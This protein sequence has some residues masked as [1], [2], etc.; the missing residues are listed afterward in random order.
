MSRLHVL[1]ALVFLVENGCV[2]PRERIDQP[3]L[4]LLV[5]DDKGAP[6]AGAEVAVYLWSHPHSRLDKEISETTPADGKVSLAQ[7]SQTE[8]VYPLCMHG[9]AEHH[10][11]VCVSH[12]GHT[13]VVFELDDPAAATSVTVPLHPGT[14]RP[15]AYDDLRFPGGPARPDLIASNVIRASNIA[16]RTAASASATAS[17]NPSASASAH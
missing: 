10:I 14:Q 6:I 2:V 3:A 13:S 4:E 11:S 8:T 16:A 1:T 17:A 7:R 12:P 9:V 5:T 15:C